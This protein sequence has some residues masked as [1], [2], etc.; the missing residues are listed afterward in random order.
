MIDGGQRR[1]GRRRGHTSR[2]RRAG[3]AAVAFVAIGFLAA[4]SAGCSALSG[5]PAKP[6]E[7]TL[8]VEF[9]TCLRAHGL[10]NFPDPQSKAAGG[11]FPSGSLNPYLNPS[12]RGSLAL[13]D[14]MP[15]FQAAESTAA[16]LRTPASSS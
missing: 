4:A 8:L 10:P 13:D 16:R 11:G 6:S 5:S 3:P 7:T 12:A 9:S 1:D 14:Y 2:L 15:Q